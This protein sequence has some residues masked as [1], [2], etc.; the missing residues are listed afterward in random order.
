MYRCDIC[1][2][3]RMGRADVWFFLSWGIGDGWDGPRLAVRA[4][5][6]A[7]TAGAGVALYASSGAWYCNHG[8]HQNKQ[9]MHART[10]PGL[11]STQ[12]PPSPSPISLLSLPNIYHASAAGASHI[13]NPY[14]WRRAETF[15]RQRAPLPRRRVARSKRQS[16]RVAASGWRSHHSQVCRVD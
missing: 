5:H 4:S 2:V 15:Q 12:R 14:R 11:T 16:G 13:R 9:R 3:S 10:L 1:G 7:T 6:H 8:G